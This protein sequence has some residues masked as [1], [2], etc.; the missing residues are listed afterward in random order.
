MGVSLQSSIVH[1][2]DP[3]YGRVFFSANE[4]LYLFLCQQVGAPAALFYKEG[5]FD[6]TTQDHSCIIWIFSETCVYCS[7]TKVWVHV[8]PGHEYTI[9]Q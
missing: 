6:R 7:P 3:Q 5:L 8:E 4:H 1:R 2:R 9:I